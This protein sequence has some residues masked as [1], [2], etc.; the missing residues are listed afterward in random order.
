MSEV[1]EGQIYECVKPVHVVV[2][3]CGTEE[4]NPELK[5]KSTIKLTETAKY[6]YVDA[7]I[8]T[9]GFIEDLPEYKGSKLIMVNVDSLNPEK[10]FFRRLR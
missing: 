5:E 8:I 3:G 1:K 4:V 2:L 10:G 9:G 6:Y 7:R